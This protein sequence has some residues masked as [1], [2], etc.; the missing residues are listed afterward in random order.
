MGGRGGR[1]RR[2]DARRGG[3]GAAAVRGGARAG[4]GAGVR[5]ALAPLLSLACLLV[6]ALVPAPVRATDRSLCF[7]MPPADTLV[8]KPEII[9]DADK[10]GMRRPRTFDTPAS[11]SRPPHPCTYPTY[12]VTHTIASRSVSG[13]CT[14][15][16][17]GST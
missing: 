5:A 17:F 13:A 1:G 14:G 4:A 2:Q 6:L 8:V 16:L 9:I 15:P 3:G 7:I 11:V 12:R 10:A